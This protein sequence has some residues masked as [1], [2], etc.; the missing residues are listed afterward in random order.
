[1]SIRTK[2]LLFAGVAL[3][4]T[5]AAGAVLYL[6]A[7]RAQELRR[8]L[9]AVDQQLDVYASMNLQ[10]WNYLTRLLQAGR[11]GRDSR[12]LLREYEQ[13]LRE[14]LLNLQEGLR[15]EQQALDTPDD[16]RQQQLIETVFE[17][18]RQWAVGVEVVL[19]PVGAASSSDSAWWE[20]F[21][22]YE[23]E[24]RPHLT[25][26]VSSERAKQRALQDQLEQNLQQGRQLGIALP[27][28][29][30]LLLGLMA[31]RLLGPL[32]RELGQLQ[33]ST[34]RIR[35]GD[36]SVELPTRREDELGLLAQALHRMA[37]ELRGNLRDKERRIQAEAEA[38]ERE[39]RQDVE[40]AA[41]DLHRYNA[42]LEQM[43]R[44]RT[45]ELENANTQ[46][47]SSLR[48]LQAMQAQLMFADRL[49]SMGRLAAGVGHE[50]N[51]PLAYVLSNLNFLYKELH[52]TGAAP[53]EEDRKELLTAVSDAKEGAERV[54]VIVQDLKTLSRPDDTQNGRTDL[55]AVVRAAVKIASHE[56][57]RRA[58]LVEELGELPAVVGNASRL[59]Q[60]FLN[61]LINAAQA[62]P[63]GQAGQNEIRIAARQETPDLVLIEIRDTGCGIPPENLDRIFDPFFTTKPV[64][65]GTGLGLSLVHS[66]ITTLGGTITVESQVNQ[67]TTFRISLP[68]AKAPD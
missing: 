27:L 11:L 61:L 45:V 10:A 2:V 3:G 38:T 29:A 20:L 35:Q 36:F 68:T 53:S 23:Q 7:S 51:N 22:T 31:L 28:A 43:V 4:L 34:E 65:E 63:E 33:T 26:A 60:V 57:R 49:A 19:R 67:G 14:N 30:G 21:T 44:A 62:I 58:Q 8:E 39:R 59:G 15:A 25:K 64:G 13:Q 50:I 18:Q 17:A 16:P 24:V 52:R 54:R 9:M 41:R 42:A 6:S 48:Q 55:K 46:L 5:A 32:V 37:Q 1:M 56:V 66:I 40:I 47:A 12:E